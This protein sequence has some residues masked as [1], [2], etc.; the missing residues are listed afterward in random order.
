NRV[1]GVDSVPLPAPLPGREHCGRPAPSV[2][3]PAPA[4]EPDPD[5]TRQGAPGHAGA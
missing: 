1:G 5:R 3:V 2:P 4:T